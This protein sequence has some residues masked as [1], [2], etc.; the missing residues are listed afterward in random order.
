MRGYNYNGGIDVLF[1]KSENLKPGM[2]L[3]KPIYN[4]NGVLLY[5]RNS[6]LTQQGIVSIIN[7]NLIGIFILEPAEPVPPMTQSDIDFECFQ[8]VNV[9]A[10][11]EEL[12]KIISSRRSPKMLS[13][14]A[15]ISK[16]YGYLDEK[17]NFIQNL[18]SAEDYVYKHSLNVAVLCAMMSNVLHMR[19]E[20]RQD[21]LIAALVHDVGKVMLPGPL[22]IK[23]DLSIGERSSINNAEQ[24]GHDL[25]EQ[26]FASNQN[27]RR[28]CVQTH[29][30][31]EDLRNDVSSEVKATIPAKIL[32]VAEVFDSMTAMKIGEEPAS[33][34][35]ALR[36]LMEHPEVFVPEI[37][38]ALIA[39][40][41]ILNPGTCVEL[42]TGDKALVIT[43]NSQ[44][45]LRPVVLNFKDNS[46]LDLS[47]RREFGDIE[48]Q[49]IMKTMDNRYIMDMSMLKA[50]GVEVKE[51]E[52]VEPVPTE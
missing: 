24:N 6:K 46:V 44:N 22:V 31:L 28:I 38:E 27:V 48:I 17:I 40:I 43:S 13:L 45:I 4:R 23:S 33:E 49:D 15:D 41:N 39:S 36:Y 18:R 42:N 20:D 11:E 35:A 47:N 52:Y 29:K 26:T 2:R 14:V 9:F 5:D 10:V 3:A 51:P 12:N 19:A 50:H 21:V 37:V 34:V 7:F 32:A 25:L 8:A 1:V 16:R 30:M